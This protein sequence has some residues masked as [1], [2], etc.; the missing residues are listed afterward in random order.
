[1]K[2]SERVLKKFPLSKAFASA[3]SSSSSSNSVTTSSGVSSSTPATFAVVSVQ[4]VTKTSGSSSKGAIY[5]QGE[6]STLTGK[7]FFRADSRGLSSAPS[8]G[9]LPRSDPPTKL[10]VDEAV[11]ESFFLYT[12]GSCMSNRN[13]HVVAC[14]AGWGVLAVRPSPSQRALAAKSLRD[15]LTA[16]KLSEIDLN[17]PAALLEGL[18]VKEHCEV[19]GSLYGPVLISPHNQ[20]S[21]SNS[22]YMGATVGKY[23]PMIISMYVYR[24]NRYVLIGSNNTGELCAIGEAM[25]YFR[26]H[27]LSIP[28]V[29]SPKPR[30]CVILYDSEYA[31]KSVLGE[32]SGAKN[33]ELITGVRAIYAST[34]AQLAKIHGNNTP[35][36]VV[37]V[38]VKAH[39]GDYF[40]DLADQL[41]N[42]GASGLTC[43]E[44]RFAETTTESVSMSNSHSSKVIDLTSV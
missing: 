37:F 3:S 25:L 38:K 43:E 12:D 13:V 10:T 19:V 41:A 29:V 44:G 17:S 11:G 36:G 2:S 16:K 21:P 15:A 4:P 32:Y 26:D 18:L 39:S 5:S 31:A 33:K 22:F 7:R 34:N 9:C 35:S 27:L 24:N 1:M 23:Y 40:N 30:Y 14:P 8:S 20:Q 28:S 6:K 42:R